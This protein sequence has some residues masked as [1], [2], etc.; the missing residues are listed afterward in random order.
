MRHALR[1]QK[2][3]PTSPQKRCRIKLVMSSDYQL[4]VTIGSRYPDIQS[5]SAEIRHPGSAIQVPSPPP[6]EGDGRDESYYG[7]ES[8]EQAPH[9]ETHQIS[10]VA[11]GEKWHDQSQSLNED[12]TRSRKIDSKW[13]RNISKSGTLCSVMMTMAVFCIVAVAAFAV[14]FM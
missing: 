3:A 9:D 10:E 5:L 11:I 13:W 14:L 2:P 7:S 12:V 8:P 6:S 1:P 4:G